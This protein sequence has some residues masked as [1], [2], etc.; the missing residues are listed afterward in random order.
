MPKRISSLLAAVLAAMLIA[1]PIWGNGLD[2]QYV[3][4]AVTDVAL[5]LLS[6]VAATT[7]V[8]K[9]ELDGVSVESLG[10]DDEEGDLVAIVSYLR[11]DVAQMVDQLENP[12][13]GR[14]SFLERLLSSASR[15]ISPL[16]RLAVEVRSSLGL[17]HGDAILDGTIVFHGDSLPSSL[18]AM[19]FELYVLRKYSAVDFEV[20]V[21]LVVSG[22]D[23]PIPLA[24]EGIVRAKGDDDAQCVSLT[25]EKMT[26]NNL[27]ISISPLTFSFI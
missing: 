4:D 14:A 17:E 7:S 8:P 1:V 10:E 18:A 15:R 24:F 9:I 27:E 26:C 13:L 22:D 20:Y 25:I 3:E 2:A 12:E 11:C 16:T 19:V 5:S 23:F 6:S 21:S